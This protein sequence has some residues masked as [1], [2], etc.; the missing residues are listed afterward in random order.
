MVPFLH[1]RSARARSP[2]SSAS[3]LEQIRC[4]RWTS[5]RLARARSRTFS[6][7]TAS[8]ERRARGRDRL[9]SRARRADRRAPRVRARAGTARRRPR[10]DA[11]TAAIV[12]HSIGVS[13]ADARA[14]PDASRLLA[15]EL[16]DRLEHPEAL[17]AERARA[18]SDEA[19]VEQRGERV[20]VGVAD[21]LGGLERAAAAEHRESSGR[22]RAR[23]RRAGRTTR[24]SS[25]GASRVAR[26]RRACPSSR[27]RRRVEPL[28]SARAREASCARQRARARAAD[29]SRRA[30]SSLTVLGRLRGPGARRARVRGRASTASSSASGGR[31]SSGSPWMRS[32]S[33]LVD[34]QP[35]RGRGRRE[36]CRAGVRRR[37]AGARGCRQTTWVRLSPTRA[38]IASTSADAAPSR[39][40]IVDS[41][42]AG[43]AKRRE[44]AEDR[45]AVRFLGE[46]SGEL[47][48]EARLAGSA[49]A[50][51]RQ[52]ARVALVHE[53]DRLEQLALAAEEAGR[54]GRQ[55]DAPGRAQRREVAVT[56]AARA[57]SRRRSP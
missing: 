19:L 48:G 7:S 57:G 23:P 32:G 14:S 2:G 45:A 8:I 38:A 55:L 3:A 9:P 13:T 22:A 52:H 4:S 24:R 17:L 26:R 47:D 20:E 16:A 31:S 25:L 41:T 50:E 34:E 43:I 40:A 30:Q 39:S 12:E 21:R 51:D 10:S 36:L 15:R 28:E 44:R 27:S 49:R 29:R 1:T 5:F 11:P 54:G 53:R 56:R 6:S 42:S 18:A 37:A 46:Q 33:R 35:Q